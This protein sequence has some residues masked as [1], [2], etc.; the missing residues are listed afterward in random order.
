MIENNKY[1]R[2]QICRGSVW[3]IE[4]TVEL[5]KGVTNECNKSDIDESESITI[6]SKICKTT[7]YVNLWYRFQMNFWYWND[8][9]V[10]AII[11]KMA[12]ED[13]VFSYGFPYIETL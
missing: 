10:Y 12:A 3:L 6:I 1:K 11:L 5:K 4:I 13:G 8:K 2:N 9:F 7:S